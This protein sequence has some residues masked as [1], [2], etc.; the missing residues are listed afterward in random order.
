MRFLALITLALSFH[1]S[2]QTT[3]EQLRALS[4]QLVAFAGSDA[5]LQALSNG[6]ALAQP[7]TLVTQ[8]ASGL[9]QIVTFTPPNALAGADVAR[10]LEQARTN[11]IARGIAQPTAQ[12]VGVAL[13]GGTI[14]TSSG[15]VN[16]VG[17]LTNSIPPNAV[18]VRNEF[19]GGAFGGATA[20]PFGSAA[21]FQALSTGLR[22]GTPITLTGTTPNG[23]QTLTFTSPSGPLAAAD[24][25]LLL[26]LANQQLASL[27]I[28]SPTPAQIQA[29]LLGGTVAVQGGTVQL[30]GVLQNRTTA[31]STSSLFG[32]SNTPFINPQGSV[33]I[34]NSGIG[35][36]AP[37]P[38]PGTT[39]SIIGV[40]GVRR[41]N[42]AEGG[43]IRGPTTGR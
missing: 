7:V 29:S 36:T 10:A 20:V 38:I 43:A 8:D 18:G 13:M 3:P 42:T 4:P 21:N 17:V 2:A 28:V 32:T 37:Q 22:Q 19:V 30:A 12:Q 40:D 41:A 5:N 16:L 31:T 33:G 23:T 34:S 15:Q 27:G 14:L 35:S 6:L 11:L 39:P 24:A 26:Q 9:L 1:A 25:Q